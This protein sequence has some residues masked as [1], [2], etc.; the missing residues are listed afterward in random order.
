MSPKIV[1]IPFVDPL[2]PDVPNV[3]TPEVSQSA[4]R[5][6]VRKTVTLTASAPNATSYYWLKNGVMI[7]GGTS[8]TLTVNWRSPKNNPTDTYQ[9]VAVYSI[10][11]LPVESEASAEMTVENRP[12]GTVIVFRGEEPSA[13][14]VEHDYS[15]DYLTFRVLTSGTISWK[16]FEPGQDH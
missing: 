3:S 13:P 9:A 2:E 14:P 1:K 8:G 10:D 4:T 11:G 6:F 7:E 15:A 5:V 16:S 12:M